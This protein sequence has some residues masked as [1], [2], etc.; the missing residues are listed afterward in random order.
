MHGSSMSI[1]RLPHLSFLSNDSQAISILDGD[2]GGDN[3]GD[4]EDDGRLDIDDTGDN[5]A[6]A[7]AVERF[8]L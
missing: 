2:N 1:T 3:D 7:A 8:V 5:S 4:G 6:T